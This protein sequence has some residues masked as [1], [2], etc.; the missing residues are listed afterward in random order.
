MNMD[1]VILTG[2]S[3]INFR[4]AFDLVDHGVLLREFAGGLPTIRGVD[5]VIQVLS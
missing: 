1:D 2:L 4:E 3:L 5:T